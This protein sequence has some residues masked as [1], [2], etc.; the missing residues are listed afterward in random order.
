[1]SEASRNFRVEFN[2]KLQRL[3]SAGIRQTERPPMVECAFSLADILAHAP[4]WT[5]EIEH[6]RDAAHRAASSTSLRIVTQADGARR[7]ESQTSS[8]EDLLTT[9]YAGA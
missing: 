6:F 3:L 1:M 2:G 4:T 5:D 9:S 7:A 8:S